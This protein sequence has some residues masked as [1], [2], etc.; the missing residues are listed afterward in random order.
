[1]R[2][3]TIRDEVRELRDAV[4]ALS[5]RIDRLTLIIYG[6]GVN[7]IADRVAA[8]EEC[9]V[10]RDAKSLVSRVQSLETM[11]RSMAW[12]LKTVLT[13]VVTTLVVAIVQLVLR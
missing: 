12:L 13:A 7:G 3:S 10:G 9:I 6:D 1:M 2:Q 8:L 11:M 5:A 4:N